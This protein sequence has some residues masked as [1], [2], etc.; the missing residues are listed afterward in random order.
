MLI[1]YIILKMGKEN[2]FNID[3]IIDQKEKYLI[4]Y[5][6]N[7]SNYKYLKYKSLIERDNVEVLALGSSRVLQFRS[8]MF[9]TTFYNAGFTIKNIYDF[10]NILRIIPK[11]KMPKYLIIGIDQWMFNESWDD[12]K[13][14]NFDKDSFISNNSNNIINGINC[15]KLV[16]NDILSKKLTTSNLMNSKFDYIPIG[17]NAR[18]NATGIRNDGSMFYGKQIDDL[19]NKNSS[20]IDFNYEDTYFRINK[21]DKRFEYSNNINAKV[22]E[23]LNIFLAYCKEQNIKVIG[24][25][26]PFA[27]KVYTKMMTSSNYKYLE[28]I[29]PTI[30][31]IFEKYNFEVYQFNSMKD[32]NSNDNETID[33]FHGGEKTY[34]GMLI[35]ILEE[36]S[37]LNNVC[38][39]SQLKKDK[40]N[41]LN[42]YLMYNY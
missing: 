40:D 34:V 42:D 3:T 21:G 33:G 14:N 8:E 36:G 22:V 2:F 16:Y 6:Y 30:K 37:V 29:F 28:K 41:S 5:S 38:D 25:I 13:S 4:G 32:C 7:E 11:N 12:L 23:I 10:E 20:A 19:L 39:L 24:I 27:D 1:P 9:N 31:P 17:L 26:P 18:V 15:F 35:S